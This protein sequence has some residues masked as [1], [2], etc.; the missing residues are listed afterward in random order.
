MHLSEKKSKVKLAF[1]VGLYVTPQLLTLL[2]I[3]LN[4]FW[5][6]YMLKDGSVWVGGLLIC[7]NWM[8]ILMPIRD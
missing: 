1:M 7:I 4:V 6:L 3:F 2:M 8:A 5:Y